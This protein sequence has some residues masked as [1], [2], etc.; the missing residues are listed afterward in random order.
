MDSKALFDCDACPKQ[1]GK[2]MF[3]KTQW[4]NRKKRRMKCRTCTE[5]SQGGLN[6]Q[7]KNAVLGCV[8]E[9]EEV[10]E[11]QKKKVTCVYA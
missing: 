11:E 4:R 1:G 3:S 7:M 9:V 10:E 8:V 2:E 6:A 5:A